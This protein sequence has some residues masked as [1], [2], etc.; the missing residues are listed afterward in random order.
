[1]SFFLIGALAFLSSAHAVEYK[2]KDAAGNWTEQACTGA[3]APQESASAGARRTAEANK[4]AR[5]AL[6]DQYIKYCS[7]L[8]Y[9]SLNSSVS[10]GI[11]HVNA[12]E[13]LQRIESENAEGSVQRLRLG[14]CVGR[15]YNE[16]TKLLDAKSAKVCYL[17]P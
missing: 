14:K 7:Q 17:L 9:R 3:A 11:D 5:E 16:A 1:M 6:L 8:G 10:C 15:N 2:C 13:Y 12:L 4:A